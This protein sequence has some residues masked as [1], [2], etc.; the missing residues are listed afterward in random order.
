MA[1]CN[2]LVAQRNL[3]EAA[4]AADKALAL[5]GISSEQ[6]QDI[7]LT[8][9]RAYQENRKFADARTFAN[10]ALDI[11][12]L[13][14]EQKQGIYFTLCQMYD[15]EG[16]FTNVVAYL[17]KGIEA[18]PKSEEAARF[19]NILTIYKPKAEAQEVITS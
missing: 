15:A 17:K 16:D 6:K 1:E 4:A 13:S 7:Y 2:E 12:G 9:C 14:G 18:D 10:K 19:E 11:P 5:P 3:D 8:L